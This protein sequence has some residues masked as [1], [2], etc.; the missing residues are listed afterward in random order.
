VGCRSR[1]VC[2]IVLG[3]ARSGDESR[4]LTSE[5]Q[6]APPSAWS[7]CGDRQ[8]ARAAI[9]RAPRTAVRDQLCRPR[10]PLVSGCCARQDQICRRQLKGAL[11]AAGAR[12]DR[13]CHGGGRTQRD[14]ASESKARDVSRLQG[15]TGCALWREQEEAFGQAEA[16]IPPDPSRSPSAIPVRAS[17]PI[18]PVNSRRTVGRGAGRPH[19]RIVT[20]G[21]ASR[22]TRSSRRR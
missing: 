17:I 2:A 1:Q 15:R 3:T 10:P 9:R 13:R 22:S 11:A 5:G 12:L 20:P 7:R 19:R 21:E 16:E 14:E 4:G 8:K 6:S 18:W